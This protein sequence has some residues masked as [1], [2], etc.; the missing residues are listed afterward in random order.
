M[1]KRIFIGLITIIII[2]AAV[3]PGT[4]QERQ[5][6]V[7]AD[8]LWEQPKM[9]FPGHTVL[10]FEGAVNHDSLGFLPVYH[11]PIPA[12]FHGSVS[13][14]SIENAVYERIE[15]ANPSDFPDLDLI[16]ADPVI[17]VST[18]YQRKVRR[19]SLY[20]LPLREASD[21]SGIEKLASFE[22]KISMAGEASSSQSPGIGR[23]DFAGHSVLRTGDWYRIGVKETGI[24]KVTYSD[25]EAMGIAPDQI[26]P[27]NIKIYGNGSG[28]LEEA[29]SL[30][31]IDD[32]IENTIYID[33]ESDGRFDLQD[34]ILFYGQS[35]VTIRY[36][37]F[38]QQYEHEINLYTDETYYF[39]TAGAEKGKRVVLAE[40]VTDE[41]THDIYSFQDLAYHE[42]E[43]VNLL[44]SGKTWYGEVF[45]TQLDYTFPFDL[46][47]LELSYPLY[48]KVYLAGRS[49]VKT[50][51][52][53]TAE[54]NLITELEVPSIVLGSQIY[55]RPITSNYEMFYADDGQV[56]IGISFAK[57]G[58]IDV[59]WLN[60]IE[61]NYRRHLR[62]HGGQVDFRDMS[63]VGP[64]NIA[65][66]HL[67][68]S[69]SDITLWD[70]TD[71][72]AIASILATTEQGGVTFKSSAETLKE[73]IA[74]DGKQYYTPVF[75]EKVENQDLHS[76]WPVD[77]IILAHPMF[78]EQAY[79]LADY[80]R[81]YD[82]MGVHVV[83]PQQVYNEFSSGAQDVSA[84]RDFMKMLYNR[85]EPGEEPR[86]L[87]L[88]GD[89]SYDYKDY[90]PEDNNLVPAYQ[91]RESLKLAAS[92]VTD[93]FFGCLDLDEG[94]SGSGTMDVGVGRFP[95]HT[96]EQAVAMADK[97]INYMVPARENFGSWRNAVCFVGDDEDNNTH[98]GQAEGLV[99][100]ADSLGPA[101]NVNKVY[102]DAYLQ[103]NT[104][105]GAR[106][107]DANS[108]I[109]KAVND[110]SL[111]INYTGHG[112]EIAWAG[113]R[114]LDIP[115][116]QSYQ[117]YNR[118]AA[119]VTATCE[120][121]RYDDPGLVSAGELVFL[122]P[123]GAGIGLFTTTRLAFSQSN[124][125]LNKRFYYEAFIIDSL[126]GEYP[127]MGDLIR[128]A[129][130]PSN[131][132]IKNFV[133]LGDPAL[134]LAYPKMRARTINVINEDDGKK[135]DT[136]SA[137]SRVTIEGQVEDLLG[138]VLDGFNGLI[139]SSVYDKPV[140]YQTR[141]NDEAS[142]VTDFYIQD[143]K[144]YEGIASVTGGKFRFTFVVPVD[145]SYQYGKGKISH[146][147]VDTTNLIDAQGHDEIWI[148]GSDNM[149]ST[150][151]QGPDINLYLNSISFV[152]GDITTPKPLLIA[153]LSDSSGINT[154]GN[155]IGHDIVAVIDGN[156]NESIILNEYFVPET[157]SYQEGDIQY[158]IGPFANGQHTLTLKAWDVLNNS[159]EKTIEFTVDTDARLMISN[160]RSCPNP[161]QESTQFEFEHNK[162]GSVLDVTIM[163]YS[164]AGQYVTSLKY[165]T[166]SES[167][168][169]GPLYWN[170]RDSSGNELPA[171]L[172]VYQLLVESDDGYFTDVSQKFIHFK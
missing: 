122:N 18:D 60:C 30:P 26:D 91:S 47:D 68:S 57:P 46:E 83:T 87:L 100:I 159:S 94:S 8:I 132:N 22:L 140:K 67:Q 7:R 113:E 40:P 135:A 1:Q 55:A 27:R 62:F 150:D 127:R 157:D 125:A 43:E 19:Q 169:S 44:K 39:L 106:Y 109:D 32:L 9:L 118:L 117:N 101:Y 17:L 5:L 138:N 90:I 155:G 167:N 20:I 14:Y 49:T 134:M 153:M 119:F 2:M 120:F 162:P 41:P 48:L 3:I 121:S 50:A 52:T 124:Y 13:G 163:I 63:H 147:A 115:A 85:A 31:R 53:I 102:L 166:E 171:G 16:Q 126:T 79:R 128:V 56:D 73:F 29:N 92:F 154:V 130:T 107:P 97:N 24:Y 74:F 112:G 10:F 51:F 149:A 15:I 88:F 76:L 110:G 75:V 111:I 133:L 38:Y 137:L 6:A 69:G 139:Y 71:P 36:N 152:S 148:G 129:K 37:S 93:D 70:V 142:K 33:G 12:G 151:E 136:I 95:V 146:Y 168:A 131:Q 98:L 108:A 28:M 11:Y 82:G 64:G 144:I 86:Y 4:A 99:V 161:Y 80:H 23:S 77:F 58:S 89:A 156:Y 35:P 104:P 160:V 170:G 158:Y 66:Y 84:I 78:L 81:Q 165:Q 116:I 59:G 34:F 172:F 54:N 65:C 25:M 61:V 164:L 21:G 42:K 114:V 143:K 123:D 145:I 96:I 141:G 72:S 103:L 105:S 45:S